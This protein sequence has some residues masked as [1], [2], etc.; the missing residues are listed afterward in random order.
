MVAILHK[1]SGK[2]LLE[3][4]HVSRN[5]GSVGGSHA[6]TWHGRAF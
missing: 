3:K 2:T 1:G 4:G 5:G 6:I